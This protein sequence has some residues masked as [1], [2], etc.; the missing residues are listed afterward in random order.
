MIILE[1]LPTIFGSQ[2]IWLYTLDCLLLE[3]PANGSLFH[4]LVHFEVRKLAHL[5]QNMLTIL[6][7]TEMIDSG[8]GGYARTVS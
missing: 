1:L 4:K 6:H 8:A 7:Q 3:F 5:S 2:V